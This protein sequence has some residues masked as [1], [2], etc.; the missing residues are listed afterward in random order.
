MKLVSKFISVVEAESASELLEANGIA[1]FISSKRSNRLGGVFTGAMYVGLWVLLD[2]QYRDAQSLLHDPGHKVQNKLSRTEIIQ[3]RQSVR[4]AD[5]TDILKVLFQMLAIVA[6]LAV[7]ITI[8][9]F[10]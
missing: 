7:V 8:V 3:L 4:S 10:T 5:M 9:V 1:T 6:L 2:N